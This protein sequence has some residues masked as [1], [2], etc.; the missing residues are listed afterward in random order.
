MAIMLK[1]RVSCL[2]A[3][4]FAFSV[5]PA[6]GQDEPK[7]RSITSDDF[8][9][10]RPAATVRRARKPKSVDYKFVRFERKKN[11]AS[12]A[13]K[14]SPT[15]AKG[16]SAKT[17]AAPRVAAN[18][19]LNIVEI[20]VT[21]WKLREPKSAE[22]GLVR[23]SVKEDAS[24]KSMIGERVNPDSIFRTG[25]K[26]RFALESSKSGFIY[27]FNRETFADGSMGPPCLIF[28]FF[29]NEDN[30]VLPG[31]LFDLPD[32]RAEPPSFKFAPAPDCDSEK[33]R[34]PASPLY[35][36]EF[37]TI[38]FSTRQVTGMKTNKVGRLSDPKQLD[39]I[40]AAAEVEI[41]RR[42]DSADRF[43]SRE[44]SDASCGET[45][46]GIVREGEPENPCGRKATPLTPEAA[47]P[48]SIF[49]AKGP[50]NQPAVIFLPMRVRE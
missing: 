2:A 22:R 24:V 16:P 31:F 32:Q 6:F 21:M 28:P 1:T 9:I 20:G 19:P 4:T 47:Q 49:R 34:D 13:V 45:K 39:Q 46:R 50:A 11:T 18:Q 48:Q 41:Y 8:R 36:G 12:V 15:A 35:T 37:L 42:T 7:M 40:E 14:T 27:I 26:I 3:L 44:E 43:Y 10:Q 29:E 38:L 25:D 23:L 5:L 17:P 30:A 33:K